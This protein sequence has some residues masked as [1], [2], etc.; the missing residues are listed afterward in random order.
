[1]LLL[2][3]AQAAYFFRVDLAAQRPELKPAL[4]EFCRLLDCSIPLPQ[5]IDLVSIE[6][7]SLEAYPTH[8]NRIVLNVLLRNRAAFAQAFPHLELTINDNQDQPLSRRV[9]RPADYLP[10][11]SESTGL[12][13]HL[14]LSTKLLLDTGDLKPSGYRLV[15]FY[16]G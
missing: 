13:A 10:P 5:K 16:P 2:L 9:F 14:E 3:L 12:Q 4:V 1:L 7:S 15:L 11:E 8:E 6:S